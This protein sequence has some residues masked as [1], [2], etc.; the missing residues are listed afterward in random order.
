MWWSHPDE[1]TYR[2]WIESAGMVVSDQHFV[3]EG[4]SGTPCSQLTAR[5]SGSGRDER[6]QEPA[7]VIDRHEAVS[8]HRSRPVIYGSC[9]GPRGRTDTYLNL[10]ATRNRRRRSWI[11]P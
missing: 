6:G 11:A 1:A 5:R 2:V 8:G 4:P 9:I 3:P 10:E 7:W